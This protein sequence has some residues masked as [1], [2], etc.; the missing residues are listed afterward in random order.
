[1]SS[2]TFTP[3]KN[4][5]GSDPLLKATVE[6]NE[7]ELVDHSNLIGTIQSSV[8]NNGTQITNLFSQ[9]SGTGTSGLKVLISD[10]TTTTATNANSITAINTNITNLFSQT[11]GTGTSG[12]KTLIDLNTAKNNYPSEHS[13]KLSLISVSQAANL[14][15]MLSNISTNNS[16]TV[17]N[18]NTISNMVGLISSSLMKTKIES[19]EAAVNLNSAKVGLINIT[20]NRDLDKHCLI[21]NSVLATVGPYANNRYEIPSTF[22]PIQWR[23]NIDGHIFGTNISI[24]N[25]TDIAF[26][27]SGLY[28]I[29]VNLLLRLD[30]SGSTSERKVELR[31]SNPASDTDYVVRAITQIS[32]LENS[33]DSY[34]TLSLQRILTIPAGVY[35]FII[36]S[37]GGGHS[38]I[39]QIPVDGTRGNGFIIENYP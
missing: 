21:R 20:Q 23:E 38:S 3:L 22:V 19:N 17:A 8:A 4:N 24:S 33:N 36:K 16:N 29:S 7:T 32:R 35:R 39:I 14:D 13:V 34:E 30:H 6:A 18:I 15:S 10:N 27:S 37:Q 11:A 9:T 1:M 28:R 31:L 2:N 12:L 26:S 25:S 5:S